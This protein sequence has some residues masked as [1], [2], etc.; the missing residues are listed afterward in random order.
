MATTLL[1][2]A[3][4]LAYKFAIRCEE[5]I[6]WGDGVTTL[7]SDE[8]QVI[9]MINEHI[10]SVEKLL[11]ADASIIV[12]SDTEDNFRKRI[13]PTYKSN[14]KGLRRPLA[15]KA[16]RDHMEDAYRSFMRPG[17]EGDDVC[18]IL[19]TSSKIIKG[20][21]IIV[22][23]DKD[24]A[25]IPAPCFYGMDDK[26]KPIIKHP[27]EAEAD[28]FHLFQTLTGDTVDGYA[29]CP[30]VGAVAA[31]AVLEDPRMLIETE[32]TFKRGARAG[33]TEIRWET[34]D[35]CSQWEAIVCQYEKAGLGEDEALRQA[36]V[37]RILRADDYNFKTK[38]PVLWT[39]R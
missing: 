4:I 25:T 31:K 11:D 33:E 12:L 5:E 28:Y 36:R 35:P 29:G 34:G 38:E 10:I 14:R 19:A 17:L 1:W 27:T 32:H 13:L 16:A 7:H 9:E 24:L 26:G 6:D 21:S 2:D 23:I 22:S 18:G 30:G 8:N 20:R 39:P 15:W 3:D 37:A